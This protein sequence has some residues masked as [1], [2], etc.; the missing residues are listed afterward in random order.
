MI[1]DVLNAPVHGFTQ[2]IN[3]PALGAAMRAAK[4]AAA[5]QICIATAGSQKVFLPQISSEVSEAYKRL[6]EA[7]FSEIQSELKA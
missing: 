3:A 7:Y 6:E 1:A 5:Q 2:N 4:A